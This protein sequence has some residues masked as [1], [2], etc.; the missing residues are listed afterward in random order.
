MNSLLLIL[1]KK[2]YFAPVWV[3]ASINIMVGTWVLYIPRV[4][5]KLAIDDGDIGIALFCYAIGGLFA[6]IFS[7]KLIDVIGVGKATLYGIVIFALL[8][9]FPIIAPSLVLLCVSLF[10][11]GMSSAFTDIAMNALVS[12]L[13]KG[14]DVHFMSAAHA[15]FSLGGVLGA[16][17]GSLVIGSITIPFIHIAVVALILIVTNVLLSKNFI[18]IVNKPIE[19]E[20][21]GFSLKLLKPILALTIISFIVMGSEGSLEQWSKL[22]LEDV[23]GVSL[24]W[25]AGFGFVIFS[26]AMTIGRFFGDEVSSRIGSYRIIIYGLLIAI[27]GY[28]AILSRS[29]GL[30]LIGFGL[31]GIGFSVIIPELFRV[32]GKAKG[33]TSSQGISI[34]AGMGFVGFMAGPAIMGSLADAF[35]LWASYLALGI[36]SGVALVA[37]ILLFLKRR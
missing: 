18:V 7:S 4:K 30:S 15:F 21:A 12:E 27:V 10:L 34:V 16:G 35:S 37:A 6:V 25:L 17:I 24:E 31:V 13:E 8:F 5:E 22:Y 26:A 23:V 28:I 36:S 32:A 1:S 9:L 14:D 19:K 20:H 29:Q 3:F 33:V 2:R 11:A